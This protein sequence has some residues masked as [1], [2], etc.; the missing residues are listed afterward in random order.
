MQPNQPQY[1]QFPTLTSA[2]ADASVATA[3]SFLECLTV[4]PSRGAREPLAAQGKWTMFEKNGSM[5]EK[6]KS[7]ERDGTRV[8]W[9]GGERG[10]KISKRSTSERSL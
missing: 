7:L 3:R 8:G 6:E 1:P 5:K 4:A 10:M 2:A 9:V